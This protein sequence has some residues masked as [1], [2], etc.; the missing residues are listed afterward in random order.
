MCNQ[1][2]E[3]PKSN[4]IFLVGFHGLGSKIF[5]FP[6]NSGNFQSKQVDPIHTIKYYKEYMY[7]KF[8]DLIILYFVSLNL[9]PR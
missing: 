9:L 5:L 4:T 8:V 2:I 7:L 3:Q 6:S 1:P